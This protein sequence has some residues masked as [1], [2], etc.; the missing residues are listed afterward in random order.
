MHILAGLVSLLAVVSVIAYRLYLV[1]QAAQGLADMAGGVQKHIRKRR[2]QKKLGDP[3]REIDDPRLAAAAMMVALAQSDSQLS[4]RE[5]AVITAQ[6]KAR[7]DVDDTLAAELLAHAR[8]LVRDVGEPENCFLKVR[9]I[10]LKTC[11]PKERAELTQMMTA[12][13][14]AGSDTDAQHATVGRLAHTLKS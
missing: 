11:G 6:M 5:E 9:P 8:W 1:S 10:I 2:W 14:E 12:V 4:E 13:A 7:F 3:L